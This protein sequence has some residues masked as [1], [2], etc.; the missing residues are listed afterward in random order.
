MSKTI[1]VGGKKIEFSH[2]AVN[3]DMHLWID[4]Y[5]NPNV[6]PECIQPGLLVEQI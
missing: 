2:T 4:G 5:H 3:G 6:C 1:T